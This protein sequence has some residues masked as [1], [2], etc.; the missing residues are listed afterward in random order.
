MFAE[1]VN[2]EINCMHVQKVFALRR[3]QKKL[4]SVGAA[5]KKT[6]AC[7]NFPPLPPVK[8]NNG[9]SL[10]ELGPGQPFSRLC[11][12]NMNTAPRGDRNVRETKPRSLSKD[13][14]RKLALND[15]LSL[16]NCFS[17][18]E[19]TFQSCW[20]ATEDELVDR[21]FACI[22]WLN[23][24]RSVVCSPPCPPQ[25]SVRILLPGAGRRRMEVLH[26]SDNDHR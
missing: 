18:C 24:V 2:T 4:F 17:G 12:W 9:P 21:E 20:F 14:W 3:R 16:V 19:F 10:S 25:R 6:F 11:F 26:H 23:S 5:C 15:K 1:A 13:L 7:E 8:K 22:N